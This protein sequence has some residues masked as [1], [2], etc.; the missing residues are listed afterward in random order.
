MAARALRGR[1]LLWGAILFAVEVLIATKLSHWRWV[2]SSLGDYLVVFL[3]YLGVLFL[4]PEAEA[5]RLALGTFLFAAAVEVSQALGLADALGLAPG[6]AAHTVLG[7][8]FSWEDL[9]MYALGCATCL[10]LDPRYWRQ[11]V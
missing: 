7:A 1:V 5:R 6:G 11:R 3:V 2:R 4:R 10:F 9:L 8:T